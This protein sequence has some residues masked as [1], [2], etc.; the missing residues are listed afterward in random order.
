MLVEQLIGNTSLT[1]SEK[2]IA[3]FIEKYPRVVIN[4]SLEELSQECFVSQASIIRLCKKLKTKGF[5]DFKI[6]LASELSDF[7]L[8][9]Q[10]IP[11][12]VPIAKGF[13]CEEI[14]QTFFNI[15]YRALESTFNGLQF[16]DIKQAASLLAN[17]DIV[18]LYGR[19]ESLIIV[20]DFHYK[21]LRIGISSQ[22]EAL[23]GFQE[24]HSSNKKLQ[25]AAL[26]VSQY[27]NSQHVTYIIDELK[28]SNIP[29]VLVTAAKKAWPY[30]RFASVTLRI[31]STESRH[32][33]GSFAS[34][35][36]MLY[37]LDCLYGQIFSLN[38]D[39]NLENLEKLSKSRVERNYYYHALKSSDDTR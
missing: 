19:G 4:L 1:E 37:V 8:T 13:N 30:D 18:R 9:D 28:A 33:I 32:K 31:S 24:V 38:Y 3:K 20:E 7:A 12:D 17:A 27:C 23:N 10:E 14:A 35:T 6:Q 21:L 15:S 11:V 26:I 39:K 22:L 16:E 5:A 29:F 34:R 2:Q 25:E 36:A